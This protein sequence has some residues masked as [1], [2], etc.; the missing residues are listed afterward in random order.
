VTLLVKEFMSI[1]SQIP[2]D[3]KPGT[4]I[5]L[6]PVGI[7]DDDR[8]LLSYLGLSAIGFECFSAGPMTVLDASMQQAFRRPSI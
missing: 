5:F 2:I 7:E 1:G 4:I 3:A 8:E 6:L